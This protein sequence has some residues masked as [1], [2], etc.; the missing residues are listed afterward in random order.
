MKAVSKILQQ[1]TKVGMGNKIYT[2]GSNAFIG[3]LMNFTTRD[4]KGYIAY[5]AGLVPYATKYPTISMRA[6]CVT[7]ISPGCA[8]M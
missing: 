4:L 2:E 7:V 8:V 5:I 6:C 1:F 3:M